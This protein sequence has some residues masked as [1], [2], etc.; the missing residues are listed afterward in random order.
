MSIEIHGKKYI[1][2]AERVKEIHAD[3][4]QFEITTEVISH[5]PVVVRATVTILDIVDTTIIKRNFTGISA[6]NPN[7]AIEKM[8][9]YEVAETSAVGRALGFAGYGLVDDI[10]TADEMVKATAFDPRAKSTPDDLDIADQIPFMDYKK[11]VRDTKGH[12]YCS[13]C[14]KVVNPAEE[15]F[16]LKKYGKVLCF[17]CQKDI[18]AEEDNDGLPERRFR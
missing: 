18:P 2:V 7:K 11:P 4:K 3:K 5:D 6:A 9:P 16:S 17:N 10:A 15:K 13:S 8:S 12:T 14:G 1:T